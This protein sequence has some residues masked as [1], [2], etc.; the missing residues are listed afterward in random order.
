MYV[1]MPDNL[2]DFEGYKSF[3]QPIDVFRSQVNRSLCDANRK[4]I[5]PSV[6]QDVFGSYY[7]ILQSSLHIQQI[8]VE[9][10]RYLS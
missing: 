7:L 1:E 2:T 4:Y 9:I 3:I 8:P 5:R 6:A 10:C